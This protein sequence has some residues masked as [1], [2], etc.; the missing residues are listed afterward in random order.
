MPGLRDVCPGCAAR[1]AEGAGPFSPRCA[2]AFGSPSPASPDWGWGRPAAEA[3]DMVP[4][5]VGCGAR[6]GSA[7]PAPSG[8]APGWPPARGSGEGEGGGRE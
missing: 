4:V 3:G 6:G 1:C 7:L 8:G 2:G 5:P